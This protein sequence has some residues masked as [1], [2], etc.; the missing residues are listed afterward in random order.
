MQAGSS[1]H[2]RLDVNLACREIHGPNPPSKDLIGREMNQQY[3]REM[4]VQTGTEFW[5]NN[6][7]GPELQAALQNG[8]VGVASNPVYIS[9]LL[10]SEPDFVR[11]IVQECGAGDDEVLAVQVIQKFVARPLALF[12][13]LFQNSQ[14]R[15][16]RVAI[17]GNPR[18]NDDLAYLL[19]E[20]E[21]FHTLGENICIK[22]PATPVGAQA[23]EELTERGWSTIG[24]MSFSVAQYIF[25][26]EAHQRGLRRT[27]KKPRCLI[28]ML[29]GLFDEYL[30]E[31]A[32]QRGITVAPEVLRQAGISTARAA[33]A[34]RRER[35]Y[36]AQILSG[37][38]TMTFHWAEAL[39]RGMV[40]TLSGSLM[41]AVQRERP[42]PASCIEASAAPET[43]REL[44]DKFPDF[45]R[46][47]DPTALRPEEFYEYGPVA[48]FQNS[49]LSGFELL[50]KQ[51]K[52][53]RT[54]SSKRLP[55]C[56]E[57]EA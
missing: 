24:T 20:A 12:H 26:A 38:A 17:Q 49:F 47:C 1:L 18:R 34:I 16:G 2:V 14:G 53:G 22:L 35:G 56:G 23:M 51:I 42:A 6:P 13:P 37:G 32:K 46:A 31:D 33:Y 5:I 40:L 50:I 48:R 27:R 39:G 8:A 28:T 25:M 15:Y 4:L 45:V 57:H 29:P 19:T 9:A 44:R 41:E 30:A 21:R 36:A 11:A 52:Q 43:V 54:A 3:F 10:K 55:I 7:A